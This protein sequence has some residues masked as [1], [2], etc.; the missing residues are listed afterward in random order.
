MEQ[1]KLASLIEAVLNTASGFIVSLLFWSWVV[2]PLWDLDVTM[3]ENLVI[4]ACFT[5]ISIVRGYV[6]RRVF[7][8]NYPQ[9]WAKSITSYL[10]KRSLE[11]HKERWR[12]WY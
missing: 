9:L 6:W 1:S 10:N 7:N 12:S 11:K 4:T 8:A 3:N 5:V 2:V